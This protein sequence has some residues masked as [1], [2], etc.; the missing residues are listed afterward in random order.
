[1]RIYTHTEMLEMRKNGMT[2][3]ELGELLGV[4]RQRVQQILGPTRSIVPRKERLTK[5]QRYQKRLD[6]RID[7]F[8]SLVDKHRADECWNW[9]GDKYPITGYGRF[10]FTGEMRYAHRLA[11]S[12]SNGE[13]P[14]G[15]CI[16]HSCDNPLC[17]NPKHLR[18][19]TQAENVADR[20]CK[21]R[22]GHGGRSPKYK[23]KR[24][25]ILKNCKTT[26]DIVS[27]AKKF[28]CTPQNIYAILCRA[29]RRAAQGAE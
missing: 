28:N 29:R 23:V 15:A 4:S 9:T 17:C 2:L 10:S 25:F 26:E 3:R 11:Y 13:I 1:M 6:N 7:K 12:L 27:V 8:W 21:L 24:D 16:L 19:G 14:P 5:D 20:D 22:G 18:A